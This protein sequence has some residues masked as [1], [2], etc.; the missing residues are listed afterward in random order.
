MDGELGVGIS[1]GGFGRLNG[2]AAVVGEDSWEITGVLTAS[3][4]TEADDCSMVMSA[5]S[6][7]MNMRSLVRW[8]ECVE[9]AARRTSAS[10]T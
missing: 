2:L 6:V 8:R 9:W 3:E 7:C 5:G 10:R 4:A 1:G